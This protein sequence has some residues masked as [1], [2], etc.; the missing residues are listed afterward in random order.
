MEPV[1]LADAGRSDYTRAMPSIEPSEAQLARFVEVEDGKPIVMINLLRYRERAAYEPGADAEPCSGRE[2]YE[3]YGLHV[4]PLLAR[5]GG[6]IRWRGDARASVIGPADEHWD[7]VLLVEYPSRSA[8]VSMVTSEDYR[9]IMHHRTAAL[10][11]S[12]LIATM[13]GASVPAL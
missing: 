12:R 13:D 11:D 7:D 10:A 4:L 5:V 2:A 3:R 8:F 9:A 6:K 1:R